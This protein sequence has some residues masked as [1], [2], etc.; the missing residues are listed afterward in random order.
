[1]GTSA[2]VHING[3]VLCY[4]YYDGHIS[5]LGE[6]LAQ[7]TTNWKNI[8]QICKEYEVFMVNA[9]FWILDPEFVYSCLTKQ[10]QESYKNKFTNPRYIN[11]FKEGTKDIVD[12][13]KDWEALI[14]W[15]NEPYKPIFYADEVY[16]YNHYKNQVFVRLPFTNYP[17]VPL[18]DL[19]GFS[20]EEILKDI[21]FDML[22]VLE[23]SEI[24]TISHAHRI[25]ALSSGRHF[26]LASKKATEVLSDDP[27]SWWN[28]GISL[29]LMQKYPL[30]I[31]A[32]LR[33]KGITPYNPNILRLLSK[34]YL[35]NNQLEESKQYLRKSNDLLK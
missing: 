8:L 24:D 23:D 35:K 5:K 19:R 3:E 21:L 14:L 26:I 4:T 1:M 34:V 28:Y 15:S 10:H 25:G 33:A 17:W 6:N 16:Q 9:K 31:E 12:N 2:I 7:S 29:E 22:G 20:H 18:N 27:N 11:G 13:I 32:Y 30:A